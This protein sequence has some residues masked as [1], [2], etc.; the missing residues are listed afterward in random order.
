MHR[1]HAPRACAPSRVHPLNVHCARAAHACTGRR[2][3]AR[4]GRLRQGRPAA[5][6]AAPCSLAFPRLPS[7]SLAFPHLLSPPSPPLS[8]RCALRE[9]HEARRG[10][11]AGFAFR[12][13]ARVLLEYAAFLSRLR[14]HLPCISL[15]LTCIS[16]ASRL[17]LA[18]T[19]TRPSSRASACPR[20]PCAAASSKTP[21]PHSTHAP[22]HPPTCM[23]RAR[24]ARTGAVLHLPCISLHLTCISA[25][26][27]QAGDELLIAS[28]ATRCDLPP[29]PT[30]SLLLLPSLTPPC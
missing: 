25:A 22:V 27:R 1:A 30:F 11:L 8:C 4:G 15:H 3:P 20:S 17:Y 29:S 13:A 12:G 5:V 23:A 7:P 16:V 26:S 28:S 24:L 18:R 6:R 14:L 21:P 2:A 9:A 10:E 19:G